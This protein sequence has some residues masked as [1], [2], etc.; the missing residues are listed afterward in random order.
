LANINKHAAF[1]Q[2]YGPW[3]LITGG[4]AGIG[5]AFAWILAEWGFNLI[6]VARNLERLEQKAAEIQAQ[7]PTIQVRTHQVDLSV[8]GA[9]EALIQATEGLDIGLLIPNAAMETNGSFLK[10]DFEDEQRLIQLNIASPAHLAHHYGRLMSERGRGGILFVSSIAGYGPTPYL[11]NYGASK[12]YVL[13]LGEALHYE[14]KPKGV[15][16]LVLSPGLTATP[17]ASDSGI[18]WDQIG[19]PFMDADTTALIGLKALGRKSSVI[20]GLVN[21]LVILTRKYLFTRAF[22][23]NFFGRMI[24]RAISQDRL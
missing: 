14:L 20:P 24:E 3:A 21:W 17:F 22:N 19:A 7:N 15:D 5:E 10:N 2:Q 18:N 13:S 16:V 4:S 8:P 23:I 6:L 1:R 12:A 9:V 11:A